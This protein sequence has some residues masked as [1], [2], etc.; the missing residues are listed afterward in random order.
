MSIW[1]YFQAMQISSSNRV[2][3]NADI[4]SNRNIK[5]IR[6]LEEKID[7]LALI[8]H[9][10]WEL[11]EEKTNVTVKELETKIEQI[12]LRDGK[13]DG[14]KSEYVAICPDCGHKVNKGR[15]NCFWCG[16][17]VNKGI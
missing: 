12:D 9:S 1:N 5:E 15:T 17:I 6:V 10:M 3:N 14:K 11:L 16:S 8:T 7:A 13:L 2:A 4:K